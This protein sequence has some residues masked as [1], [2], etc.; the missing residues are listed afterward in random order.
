MHGRTALDVRKVSH[1]NNKRLQEGTEDYYLYKTHKL[2]N[3][4]NLTALLLTMCDRATKAG[5]DPKKKGKLLGYKMVAV[6]WPALFRLDL[7]EPGWAYAKPIRFPIRANKPI[8]YIGN[9][10]AYWKNAS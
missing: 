9:V 8:R 7:K 10:W 5:T 3:G 4:T 2:Y 1:N 6:D